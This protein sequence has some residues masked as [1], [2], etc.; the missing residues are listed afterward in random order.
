M[1]DLRYLIAITGN[2]ASGKSSVASLLK[3]YGYAVIDAD[4]K[5]R[6]ALEDKEEEVKSAFFDFDI[7]AS[8]DKVDRAKLG[9][10]IFSDIG[11]KEK[12]EAILHP[13][14]YQ[15]ILQEARALEKREIMYFLDIPLLFE[16][17]QKSPTYKIKNII[18][19]RAS[20]DTQLARLKAR[21]NLEGTSAFNRINAQ[22]PYE[23]KT[24]HATYIIDN[25]GEFSHL[26]RQVE[27]VLK[28]L[29]AKFE[30]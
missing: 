5:A 20:Q 14:I 16:I 25:N 29:K 10:L 18:L 8:D 12:L 26:Q 2:I 9:A 7:L 11:A 21:D 19:I 15:L 3:L 28:S 22:L 27:A 6:I 13:H 1:Q 24:P 4:S 17:N 30:I 23:A